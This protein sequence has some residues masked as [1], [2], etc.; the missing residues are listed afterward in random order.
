MCHVFVV[1]RGVCFNGFGREFAK[2]RFVLVLWEE[3]FY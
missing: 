1:L 3:D 2:S